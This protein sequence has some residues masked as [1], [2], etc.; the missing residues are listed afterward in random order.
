METFLCILKNV[1]IILNTKYELSEGDYLPSVWTQH[2]NQWSR[3]WERLHLY[4]H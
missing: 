1:N 2:K 4:V 3:I